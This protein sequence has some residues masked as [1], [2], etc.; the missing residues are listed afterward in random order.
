MN[1]EYEVLAYISWNLEDAIEQLT[2]ISKMITPNAEIDEEIFNV[3]MADLYGHLNTA[4]NVRH[5]KSGDLNSADGEQIDLW[6]QFPDD[7]KPI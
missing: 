4:W 1:K 7:I 2:K 3:G 5:L 6:K